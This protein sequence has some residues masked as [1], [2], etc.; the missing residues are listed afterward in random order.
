MSR[1]ARAAVDLDALEHNLRRVREAAPASR[2]MAVIKADAYGHGL[3]AAA[4]ALREADGFAVAAIDEAVRLREAGF[5]HPV[6]LLSGHHAASDLPRAAEL[7]LAAALHAPE[8]LAQLEATRLDVR[9]DVWVKVDTGMHRLGFDP[10]QVPQVVRRLRSLA[11]VGTIGLM[12]HLANADDTGDTAT[13]RQIERFRGCAADHDGPLS[14][15]NSAGVLAWRQSHF[16]WVRPGIMLYGISPLVSRTGPDLDLAPA[17]TLHSKLVAVKRAK[18]GDP[19]GYGGT[20]RCPAD[21]LLGVVACGYGDGYPRHAPSGTPV[22]VR[23]HPA[24]LAG[25]V[26]MDLMSLDLR[27][28]PDPRVGDPVLLWGRELPA[29]HVADAAGTIAYELVCGVTA[30]VPRDVA[31]PRESA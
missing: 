16:D 2:V 4:E 24:R 31:R 20:W 26:S 17:M 25:R 21:M 3:L 18:R 23:D 29:E 22:L 5:I 11:H 12:S 7:K 14:L 8:Q 9:L 30:R 15:A 19:V 13:L 6:T 1:P 27:E 10:E 28:V